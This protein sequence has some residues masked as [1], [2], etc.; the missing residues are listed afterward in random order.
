M[1]RNAMLAAMT[2][3]ALAG[4]SSATFPSG[5]P[6]KFLHNHRVTLFSGGRQVGV[7]TTKG[8]VNSEQ[9]K[10]GYDFVDATTGLRVGLTGTLVI[11]EFP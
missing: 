9:N 3:L 2:A 5:P 7:W 4:C 1:K 11:E 8:Q 6:G 10:D